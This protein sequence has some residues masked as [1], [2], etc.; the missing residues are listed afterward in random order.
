MVWSIDAFHAPHYFFPRNCPR[1]C[2]WANENTSQLDIQRF[3]GL[4]SA[5]RMIAIE[6]GWMDRIRTTALYRYSF[7]DDD[8]TMYDAEAGYYTC[9]DTVEPVSVEPMGDL[10]HW[11]SSS[12]IELRITPSLMPLREAVPKSSVSFSMIRMMHASMM[13]THE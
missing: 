10:L 13:N 12:G 9:Y 5:R 11:L 1:I 3:F 6:S 8:F 4:S 7:H 2:I